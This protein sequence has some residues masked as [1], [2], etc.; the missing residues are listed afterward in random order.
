M[1]LPL[2]QRVAYG[3]SDLGASLTFVAVNTWLLYALINIAGVPALWAGAIF[4]AGRLVDAV[5]D[6]IMG[7]FGDRIRHR[8][9]RLIFLRWGAL[10]LAASFAALWW[11]PALSPAGQIG[12]G[13]VTFVLFGIAYTVVQVPTMALTPELAPSYDE[14]TALTGWRIGFGVIA[15]MLAVA[16]PPLIVSLA[17]GGGELAS[18]DPFGWRIF[19]IAF[20]LIAAAAYLTT[21]KLVREPDRPALASAASVAGGRNARA[22]WWSAFSATGYT[23]VWILFL[24]VT[25]GIMTLNSMLPFFLESALLLSANEQTL[26]LGTLFGV[27]VLSFPLWGALSRRWG[28][29]GALTLGLLLL[30]SATLTLVSSAPAG[31]VG[32]VLLSLTAL[33]GIGLAAVMMLPWAMLPDVVEFDAL[34][35]GERREGLLYALFTFGQK[36]AGSLGVFANAWVAATFGYVQGQAL[37]SAET[38]IGIRLMT[39]PVAAA[40]FLVAAIWV[41]TFPI[42][43]E[44]HEQATRELASRQSTG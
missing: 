24:L 5:T 34:R 16:A 38:L 35:S 41:W 15:S 31:E 11:A 21:A 8:V 44:R 42:T 4:I 7:I 33:A 14:R 30:A 23:S 37:Q 32:G 27:A 17:V 29:R 20:G 43:R 25:L 18:S 10:P 36:V 28:K 39:G 13:L 40:I 3:G 22:P 6:P 2:I 12:Y 1:R 26:V 19:G 9:G